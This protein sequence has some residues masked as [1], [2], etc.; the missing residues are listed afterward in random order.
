MNQQLRVALWVALL[1]VC[2]CSAVLRM[3]G[4]ARLNAASRAD[5]ISSVL[6]PT[7]RASSLRYKLTPGDCL[8]FESDRVEPALHGQNHL[9]TSATA[10]VLSRQVLAGGDDEVY[11]VALCETVTSQSTAADGKFSGENVAVD[12]MEFDLASDGAISAA[13]P[14]DQLDPSRYFPRLPPP[15]KVGVTLPDGGRDWSGTD[16]MDQPW[17]YQ[18][19]AGDN[20]KTLL[21]KAMSESVFD[22]LRHTDEQRRYQFDLINRRIAG[23]QSQCVGEW[24]EKSVGTEEGRLVSADQSSP[25]ELAGINAQ[26]DMFFTARADYERVMDHWIG[27]PSAI[28]KAAAILR[29]AKDQVQN[30]VLQLMLARQFVLHEQM[31]WSRTLM[32]ENARSF[33]GQPA[34]SFVANDLYG[35][36]HALSDYRGKVVVLDF[37]NRSCPPCMMEAP[38]IKEFADDF[39]GRPVAVLGMYTT[40]DSED[41][42]AVADALTMTYPTLLASDLVERFHASA[43]PTII[44]IDPSG[45]IADVQIGYSH[46]LRQELSETTS[47]LLGGRGL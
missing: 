15:R 13:T 1:A 32:A 41:A 37:W 33:I 5:S 36:S 10:W 6:D 17:R 25:S 38:Q 35:Q 8:T 46:N 14:S 44:V 34:P 18:L 22:K 20:R 19:L 16:S 45:V 29:R 23:W 27:D 26:C 24:P 21:I 4:V 42:R 9:H 11:R 3:R 31:I 40:N 12:A 39:A 7:S 30:H 43:W 28:E 47:R 2:V